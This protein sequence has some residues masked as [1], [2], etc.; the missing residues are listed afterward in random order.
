MGAALAALFV[1]LAAM[2]AGAA[3]GRRTTAIAVGTALFAASYLLQGLAGLVSWIKPLRVLSPLYHATGTEPIRHGLPI[4]NYAVLV[5]LC[6]VT[7]VSVVI[8]F[9]RHDITR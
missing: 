1:G 9:D 3:T 5:V 8:V 7:A 6:V 4:G 2:V